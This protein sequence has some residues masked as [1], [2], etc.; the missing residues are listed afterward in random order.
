MW[1]QAR[2][3]R[4]EARPTPAVPNTS[5]VIARNLNAMTTTDINLWVEIVCSTERVRGP[6]RNWRNA[7]R[8]KYVT[9]QNFVIFCAGFCLAATSLA[10]RSWLLQNTKSKFSDIFPNIGRVYFIF[11]WFSSFST[12]WL[13]Y[14]IDTSNSKQYKTSSSVGKK[15]EQRKL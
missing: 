10:T 11:V 14:Y 15:G 7:S 1:R 8:G 5:Y 9:V 2:N 6:S 4:T 12:I 3:N 13:K